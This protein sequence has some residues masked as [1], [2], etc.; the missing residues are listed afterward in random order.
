MNCF[1]SRKEKTV[2]D[3]IEFSKKSTATTLP[4]ATQLKGKKFSQN[5]NLCPVCSVLLAQALE[6]GGLE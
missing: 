2:Y 1:N 5:G 3:G 6:P 4:P